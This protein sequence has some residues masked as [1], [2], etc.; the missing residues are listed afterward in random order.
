L[1]L[2]AFAVLQRPAPGQSLLD[3]ASEFG[4][5][6]CVLGLGVSG[7]LFSAD[8]LGRNAP[9]VVV[10]ALLIELIISGI[11]LRLKEAAVESLT[12]ATVNIALGILILTINSGV[13]IVWR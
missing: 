11:C 13:A 5:D 3:Q 9:A 12:K 6:L 4:V 7:A 2:L 10:A 1:A 8:S